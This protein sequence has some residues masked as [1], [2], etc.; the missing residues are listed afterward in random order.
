[1]EN[2]EEFYRKMIEHCKNVVFESNPNF[3]RNHMRINRIGGIVN[4]GYV[5][6]YYQDKKI[7]TYDG[8]VCVTFYQV[9]TLENIPKGCRLYTNNRIIAS[10][11]ETDVD[12][13][14][15]WACETIWKFYLH[16]RT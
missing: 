7:S 10:I 12:K 4:R 6:W 3:K 11:T 8:N 16:I 13:A 15:K 9:S 5:N 14:V 2:R 1:M